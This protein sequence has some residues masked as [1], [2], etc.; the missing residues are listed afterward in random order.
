MMEI[1]FALF[2]LSGVIK[3]FLIYFNIAL[4]IDLTLL[5]SIILIVCLV[6]KYLINPIPLSF[7]RNKVFAFIALAL[8]YIWLLLSL[9]YTPSQ[10]YAKEKVIYFLPNFIAFLFPLIYKGFNVRKFFKIITIAVPL[11]SI[12]FLMIFSKW[13]GSNVNPELYGSIK[14]SYLALS[15]LLGIN[16]LVLLTT[17][18]KMFDNVFLNTSIIIISLM[19][20]LMLGARGPIVFMGILLIGIGLKF[21]TK[22]FYGGGIKENLIRVMFSVLIMCSVFFAIYLFYYQEINMLFAR[23]VMRLDLILSSSSTAEMGDSVNVRIQ[24]LILSA[25]LVTDN[26][27][28]SILGYGIGSFGIL[29]NGID[30]RSYPHNIFLEIWVELG[31]VGL[32]L[33]LAFLF[34]VFTKD[35][36]GKKYVSYFVLLFIILNAL[37]SNSFVDIRVYYA[38][39]GIFL[40]GKT[41]KELAK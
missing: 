10:I 22:T 23:S 26:V 33:F 30:S 36:S 2:Y 25:K 15:A 34:F 8:F 24:Q 12:L 35:Y 28:N 3:S 17:D 27:I 9:F 1:F 31:I 19:L 20:M 13:S 41:K 40:V 18:I 21:L 38:I 6:V 39:F 37:K 14:G 7:D 11:L 29:E 32:L 4:P 5:T 16:A